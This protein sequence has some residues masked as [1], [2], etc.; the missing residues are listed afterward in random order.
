MKSLCAFLRGVNIGKSIMKMADV[1]NVFENAG[2]KEVSTILATGNILFSSEK[3]PEDL[4]E[5]LEI[6]MS[7][8]FNYEAFLFIKNKTEIQEIVENNP[9]ETHPEFHIYAFVGI[10][11]IEKNLIK[12]FENCT[13]SLNEK[14]EISNGNFYWQVEKD[15]TL[16]SEFGK[17]LGRKELKNTFTSRNI[18]TFEK[19]NLK[20]K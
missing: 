2:M 9:F 7:E 13:P 8:H 16:N 6:S 14:A 20:L 3:S 10:D 15:N 1:K 17:I 18:N 4:K 5:I 19:I 11:E 12:E